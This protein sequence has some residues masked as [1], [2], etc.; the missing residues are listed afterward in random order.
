[1][2]YDRYVQLFSRTCWHI[3]NTLKA[4]PDFLK[5]MAFIR[6][7]K[8][9]REELGPLIFQSL[10]FETDTKY[11]FFCN[12]STSLTSKIRNLSLHFRPYTE[13]DFVHAILVQQLHHMKALSKVTITVADNA[14][15]ELD[16]EFEHILRR[17]KLAHTSLNSLTVMT[18]V[19]FATA[20]TDLVLTQA[21]TRLVTVVLPWFGT[22]PAFRASVWTKDVGKGRFRPATGWFCRVAAGNDPD[23]EEVPNVAA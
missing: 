14:L 3:T 6:T 21:M 1:M 19:T 10:K 20:T 15:V 2:V 18:K 16:R 9:V 17:F 11:P 5:A 22:R 8:L 4:D 23:W 12:I 7:C 13:V